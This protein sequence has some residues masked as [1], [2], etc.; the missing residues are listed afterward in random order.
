MAAQ[1]CSCGEVGGTLAEAEFAHTR[2]DGPGTDQDHLAPRLAHPVQLIGQRLNPCAIESAV[3]IGDD[4]GT[5]LD[6]DG[7]RAVHEFVPE[8]IDHEQ[9]VCHVRRFIRIVLWATLG[10]SSRARGGTQR[11]PSGW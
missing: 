8:G 9:L 1:A 10:V 5:D 7:P 4:V 11:M 6:H 2:P 3:C